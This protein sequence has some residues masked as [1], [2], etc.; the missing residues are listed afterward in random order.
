M[1]VVHNNSAIIWELILSP[2]TQKKSHIK[3]QENFQDDSKATSSLKQLAHMA[4]VVIKLA[5]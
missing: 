5:Q 3:S 4:D 1:I 2:H